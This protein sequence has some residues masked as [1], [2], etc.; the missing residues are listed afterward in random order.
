MDDYVEKAADDQ[1]EQS[2]GDVKENW[3]EQVEVSLK[4]CQEEMHD[5]IVALESGAGVVS[6]GLR[7]GF[8][9]GTKEKGTVH[10]SHE[11][12]L[13]PFRVD[14]CASWIVVCLLSGCPTPDSRLQ[15]QDRFFCFSHSVMCLRNA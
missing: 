2:G 6:L 11:N 15:T 5:G 14:S 4:R 7:R 8:F 13:N 1:A 12:A 9:D 10:E 3:R